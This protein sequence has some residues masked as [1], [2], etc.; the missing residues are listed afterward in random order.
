MAL[1]ASLQLPAR[2]TVGPRAIPRVTRMYSM[3]VFEDILEEWAYAPRI[4]PCEQL[5]G[6]YAGAVG[7]NSRMLSGA[8]ATEP[9]SSNG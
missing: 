7:G 5:E 8:N 2:I 9:P 3:D 4:R 1:A 6:V